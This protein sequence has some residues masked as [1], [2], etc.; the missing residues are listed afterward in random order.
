MKP[1]FSSSLE[2]LSIALLFVLTGVNSAAVLA[3]EPV[4]DTKPPSHSSLT[5]APKV[6]P[7]LQLLTEAIGTRKLVLIG[8]WHGTQEIPAL[9][10]DLVAYEAKAGKPIVLALEITSVDQEL[11]DRYMRSADHPADKAKL[12]AGKHWQKPIHD[13]RDS[14][15]MFALI[16]R[17]RQLRHQGADVAVDFFDQDGP[18]ERNKRMADHLRNTVLH[19]AHATVLVLTGNVHA[20]TS[21]PP[22]EMFDGGKRV[23]LPMTAGRYLADLHPL[24]INITAVTGESW[25]CMD[26]ACKVQRIP[27]RPAISAT[28]WDAVLEFESPAESAWNATLMLPLFSPSPPALTRTDK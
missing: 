15:A 24:S 12:L 9:V 7:P 4:N 13:G 19:S 17:M 23:E 5:P 26:G 6:G 3:Q 27:S 1:K 22:Q 16:E 2:A 25:G 18:A 8:E 14:Q 10:G 20:M 21:A 11:V 28:R